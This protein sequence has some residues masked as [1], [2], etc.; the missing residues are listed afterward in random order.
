MFYRPSNS[1]KKSFRPRTSRNWS[2]QTGFVQSQVQVLSEQLKDLGETVSE[3]AVASM[4]TCLHL[5]QTLCAL[6]DMDLRRSL[7]EYLDVKALPQHVEGDS[8]S[9]GLRFLN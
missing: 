8:K 2:G 4:K 9:Q 7:A 6:E 3:A 1:P 5:L